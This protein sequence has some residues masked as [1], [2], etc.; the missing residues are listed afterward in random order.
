MK[1]WF[2]A[3]VACSLGIAPNDEALGLIHADEGTG[4][5][6]FFD[7]IVPDCLKNLIADPKEDGKFNLEESFATNFLVYFDEMHGITRRNTDEFKKVLSAKE[8]DVYLPRESYPIRRKRIGSACFT[9]NKTPELGGFLT[10]SMGYRRWII[11][12]LEHINMDYSKKVNVDQLWAE[13]YLLMQQDYNY[14]WTL[15][16]WKEFREYNNRYL[17][18]SPS[19]NYVKMH[20]DYPKNGEGKWMQPREILS[21]MVLN[22]M[23]RR[24]DIQKVNDVKIGEA[25]KN[26]SFQQKK[27]RKADGSKWRYYVNFI[28]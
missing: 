24:E 19:M 4:K 18:Q 21:H 13:A 20:L 6:F 2:V 17:F 9:S 15:I 1:K 16:E 7:F 10:N 5:S 11:L 25:L 23:V 12:E 28:S 22:K 27:V 26:L 14:L 3:T 8:I